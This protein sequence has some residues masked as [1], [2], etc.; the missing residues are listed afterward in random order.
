MK[1]AFNTSIDEEVLQQFKNKC[2]EEKLPIN[3]V[4][5]M[6]MQGYIDGKFS[7]EMKYSHNGQ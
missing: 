4:L 5:E 7:L 6:F 3:V 2:K 1:K